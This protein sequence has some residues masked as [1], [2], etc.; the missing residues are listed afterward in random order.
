[1]NAQTIDELHGANEALRRRLAE[2]EAMLSAERQCHE[3]AVREAN[4]QKDAFLSVLAHDLRNPLVPM[5]NAVELLRMPD[6]NAAQRQRAIHIIDAQVR[7]LGRLLDELLDV[8]RIIRGKV[9]LQLQSVELA[10]AV[11]RAVA[12]SRDLIDRRK[13]RLTVSLPPEPV[14]VR[15][16]PA[17][18]TQVIANLLNNSAQYTD[19][20]GRIG[21]S[22]V[23]AL[24]EIILRVEDNGIGIASEHL[25]RVFDLFFKG[26]GSSARSVGGFGIGLTV[27][28]KLVE[29]LGGSVQASSDGLGQ[30]TTFLVRL[31]RLADS[32]RLLMKPTESVASLMAQP[33]RR[34]L[35][36]ARE[37]FA[38]EWSMLLRVAGH[39]V[40]TARNL[41]QA[42]ETAQAFQP[43][44]ISVDIG[45]PDCDGPE[46]ARRL[47]KHIGQGPVRVVAIAESKN[48]ESQ[49]QAQE[50]GWD[51]LFAKPVKIRDFLNYV[52]QTELP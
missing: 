25:P 42:M 36:A 12:I 26:E 28:R 46:V 44:V 4:R 30:G 40:Q 50:A 9:E 19:E 48:E 22:A 21:L 5:Q 20:D 15:A 10:E 32:E 52:A 51:F 43:E 35:V 7:N 29:L 8:S 37:D 24:N 14:W 33:R 38:Q 11:T 34:I 47:R 45:M 41:V 18:L 13:H 49:R 23:T 1:M 2:V 3:D 17:R 27:V 16:D 31:P 6:T 39:E